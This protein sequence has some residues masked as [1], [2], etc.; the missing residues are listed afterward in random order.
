[1]KYEVNTQGY[2]DERDNKQIKIFKDQNENEDEPC[3]E[4]WENPTMNGQIYER[5]GPL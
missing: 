4:M 3:R 5:M 1:M 2:S